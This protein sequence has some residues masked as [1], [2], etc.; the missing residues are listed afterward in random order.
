MEIFGLKRGM[1][2]AVVAFFILIL[3][4]GVVWFIRS[5]PPRILIMTSGPTGSAFQTNAERYC[6]ILAQKNVTLK[7]LPSEGSTQNLKRLNDPKFRVDVGFVQGGVTNDLGTST[8]V[9]LGSISY[10]PLLVFYRA[11]A[12]ITLLS[13]FTGKRVAI[14]PHGS[15]TRSLALKLL[16]LNGIKP[17]GATTLSDLEAGE[18]AKALDDGTVDAVFMMGDSAS[19]RLIKQLLFTPGVR[20][21]DFVQA[22]GY[23]RSVSYLNKLV[24][25]RGALDYGK[26]IPPHD[27]NLVGPTVEILARPSLHPALSDLL[28][29]AAQEVNGKPSLLKRRGEFPAPLEHDFPISPDATR[30]YKSGKTF[31]YRLLPFWLA[32]RVNVLFVFVPLVVLAFPAFKVLPFLMRLRM[33]LLIY[34]WYRELLSFE[35]ELQGD[36]AAAKR[37]DLGAELNQIEEAVNHLKVPPSF[38]NQFY[39]LR[40][41]IQ[42]VRERLQEETAPAPKP[43]PRE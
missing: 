42:L 38:A 28:L 31:F 37:K 17:G 20:L 27:I 34:R 39:N 33:S 30:Y 1:A 8:L 23:T 19:P 22:D 36:L 29:E 6:K 35:K 11:D 2:F 21:V 24:L 7:I 5:A 12:P 41:H 15:G 14:G 18:A 3:A 13:E 43:P 40:A 9:S 16:D 25:P 26:D 4:A 32:S 10:E